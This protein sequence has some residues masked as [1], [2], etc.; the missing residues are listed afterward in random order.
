M[1][2]VYERDIEAHL[3]DRCKA[4]GWGCYKFT[5]PG[6]RNVPDRMVVVP[7]AGEPRAQVIFVELK[8]PGKKPTAGQAREHDRLRA[9]GCRVEMIDSVEGVDVFVSEVA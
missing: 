8:A 5:S 7:P 3:V 9:L 2:T 1:G 6:R 4:R